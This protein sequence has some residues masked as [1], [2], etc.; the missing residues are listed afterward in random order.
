M[1]GIFL[2]RRV[3]SDSTEADGQIRSCVGAE[4]VVVLFIG[5]A[6]ER[7]V[8]VSDQAIFISSLLVGCVAQW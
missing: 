4:R 3:D 1:Y 6:C 5:K 2:H 7:T 8:E